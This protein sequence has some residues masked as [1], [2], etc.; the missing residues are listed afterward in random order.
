[1]TTSRS[2]ITVSP[3]ST[4][5]SG[6]CPV[7]S[8]PPPG[9][10]RPTPRPRRGEPPRGH[11]QTRPSPHPRASTSRPRPARRRSRPP[12]TPAARRSEPPGRTRQS[13]VS[14]VPWFG[15][16]AVTSEPIAATFA[17]TDRPSG[18]V[19]VTASPTETNDTRF[20]ASSIVTTVSVAATE[21]T[22]PPEVIPTRA[23]R[24]TMRIGDSRTTTSEGSTTPVWGRP[25]DFC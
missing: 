15:S 16:P 9:R 7:T 1:M 13:T 14:A 22:L 8:A 20:A 17:G 19:T 21:S 4:D 25:S 23:D 5:S 10:L 24:L 6:R 2:S 12:T 18:R 3:R 11:R